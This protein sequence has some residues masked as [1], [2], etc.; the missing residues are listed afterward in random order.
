MS[1][2]DVVANVVAVLLL[3][4]L[5]ASVIFTWYRCHIRLR[6]KGYGR[7][8]ISALLLLSF[9]ATFWLLS[10]NGSDSLE[11]F[12]TPMVWIL[13]AIGIAR[14]LPTRAGGRAAPLA[15]RR[16]GRRSALVPNALGWLATFV[17]GAITMFFLWQLVFPTIVPRDE[18]WGALIVMLATTLIV[19]QYLVRHSAP[20]NGGACDSST[21]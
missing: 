15:P 6:A 21:I 4:A 11:V 13:F 18:G 14:V 5:A 10:N 12:G 20:G 1:F 17:G 9:A 7:F 19:S 8:V 2:A 16:A 3:L